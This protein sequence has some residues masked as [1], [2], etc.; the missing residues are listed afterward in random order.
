MHAHM[1]K[2]SLLVL[3]LTI[4][5]DLLGFGIVIP[6]LP[7]Y[8]RHYGASGWLVGATVAVYSLMQFFFSPVWGRLSDRIGRRPVMLI[9]LTG[10]VIGYTA[11]AFSTSLAMLFASRVIAG[12]AAANIGTAQAYVADSTTSE[13][14]AR[15]M[16]LIGA[17]FGLG[18]ILGPPLGGLLAALGM[19]FGWS[20][21]FLPGLVASGL[22]AT[23]LLIAFFV[24]GE[25]KKPGSAV[26]AGLPPQFDR[27][28]WGHV[29][30]TRVLALVLLTMFLTILAFAGMETTVTLYGKERFNFTPRDFGYFFGFMGVIVAGIQGGLIG[31]LSR[32]F[33]EKTLV[34]AG[35]ASLGLGLAA[36]PLIDTPWMLVP[37]AFLV[38][39]G[40]GLTYPSLTSL[41]TKVSPAEEHGSML[42]IASSVGSLS[43]MVGPVLGGVLYD[44]AGGR[45]AFFGGALISAV[46]VVV[47]VAMRRSGAET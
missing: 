29:L 1:R 44:A 16:G 38:A 15:G 14:R 47:A 27:K 22:S 30:N 35:A 13:N 4:F 28:I 5:V 39:V 20:G 34:V 41:V 40:Q 42:G 2:S 32:A 24:L 23:A 21:N 11:F 25:S 19:G 12:I 6:L 43:R 18:F 37:V 46:A 8:A 10:G 7:F 3:F 33:G 31:R 26:R 9:S 17:A 36:I 45:G